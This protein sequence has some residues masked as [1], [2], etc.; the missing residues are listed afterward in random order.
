MSAGAPGRPPETHHAATAAGG[1]AVTRSAILP[2]AIATLASAAG[3]EN[4]L[5]I[6]VDDLG[7]RNVGAYTEGPFGV[8]GNP[9]PTPAIDALAAS[10]VLYRNAWSMPSC[11]PTRATL[12]TGR[13]PFRHG[14]G[15][16][17]A[18]PGDSELDA[19]EVILPETLAD[20]GY[21]SALV[22]KY[23]LDADLPPDPTDP[24]LQGFDYYAGN[25]FGAVPDY[26]AW[27]KTVQGESFDTTTYATTDAVDEAL[28]FI[29]AQD[30]PWLCVVAFNAAHWPFHAPPGD[31]FTIPLSGTP[32]T[33]PVDHYRAMVE[34]MDTELA[35]LFRDADEDGLEGL[36]RDT[37]VIFL[38]DNGTPNAAAT[39]LEPA[40]RIKLTLYEGG[41]NVP[42]I[43]AGPRIARPGRTRADLVS[44][45]DVFATTLDA[46]GLAPPAGPSLDAV[47]FLPGLLN[48]LAPGARSVVAS[49]SF[50]ADD[51][52]E[53]FAAARDARYKLISGERREAFYDLL[54]DPDEQTDLLAAG[55]GELTDKQRAALERL[56]AEV[57]RVTPAVPSPCDRDGDGDADIADIL[58]FF[59]AFAAGEADIDGD[60]TQDIA[61]ILAFFAAFAACA[62]PA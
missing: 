55:A 24:N 45:A 36:L 14:V 8:E 15:L 49:Q 22:G 62:G 30:G 47:S 20:A 19:A 21:T 59:A 51:P 25:L 1:I 42:F 52:S 26:F 48:P 3:A 32:V 31:L 5:I 34:A 23:H 10:G 18:L 13:Y 43:V 46:A 12:L 4:F 58:D 2:I 16:A 53:G 41:I 54:L 40:G 56:R 17:I 28:G 6:I 35:R 9:P 38:A 57:A 37:W 29:R 44:V 11:S 27:Q 50:F 39:E 7:T 61:D 33:E 60:G